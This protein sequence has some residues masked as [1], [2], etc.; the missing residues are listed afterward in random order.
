M[1][2]INSRVFFPVP[3]LKAFRELKPLVVLDNAYMLETSC[4]YQSNYY[5]FILVLNLFANYIIIFRKVGHFLQKKVPGVFRSL[6]H[7]GK[8]KNASAEG[9]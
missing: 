3:H 1:V 7:D 5:I 8:C 9:E 6:V 2:F 4:F